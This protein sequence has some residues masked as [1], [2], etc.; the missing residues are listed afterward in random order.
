MAPSQRRTMLRLNPPMGANFAPGRDLPITGLPKREP[1]SFD[2][3]RDFRLQPGHPQR[4]RPPLQRPVEDAVPQHASKGFLTRY[5]G[6]HPTHV[7]HDHR[8][9]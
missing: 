1:P 5:G 2:F 8:G 7:Q 3:S 4:H 9:V 6:I